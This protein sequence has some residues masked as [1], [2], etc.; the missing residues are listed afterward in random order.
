MTTFFKDYSGNKGQ[1][2][3]PMGVQAGEQTAVI[4]W[5]STWLRTFRAVG[6]SE[7]ATEAGHGQGSLHGDGAPQLRPD[8]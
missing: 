2:S 5:E 7:R 8:G 6:E 4:R 3:L 1:T